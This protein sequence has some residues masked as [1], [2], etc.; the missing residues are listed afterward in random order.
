M[1]LSFYSQKSKIMALPKNNAVNTHGWLQFFPP[2]VHTTLT[3]L[4]EHARL[5]MTSKSAIGV[6]D[7]VLGG[8]IVSNATVFVTLLLLLYYLKATVTVHADHSYRGSEGSWYPN[9]CS[10]FAG[11]ALS[12]N[13]R[14][15]WARLLSRFA[16]FYGWGF[17]VPSHIHFPCVNACC[18]ML[19]RTSF[20]DSNCALG[21]TR[22]Q[23][24]Q[25][26]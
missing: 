12:L 4:L 20:S 21:R 9:L 26:S 6:E 25:E 16:L 5:F 3:R 7:P 19:I 24:L 11:N 1:N 14:W 15:C 18:C 2:G 22:S 23:V 13:R 17:S 10:H 8:L